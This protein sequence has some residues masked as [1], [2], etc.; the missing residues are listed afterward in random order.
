MNLDNNFSY[1]LTGINRLI[2]RLNEDHTLTE[3]GDQRV[4]YIITRYVPDNSLIVAMSIFDYTKAIPSLT[5]ITRD[6]INNHNGYVIFDC[7]GN[8]TDSVYQYRLILQANL[9]VPFYMLTGEFNYYKNL[10][11]NPYIKFFPFWT[12]WASNPY[13]KYDNFINYNFS[14]TPKKYKLSC[15]NGSR[16]HHR[17]WTYLQLTRKPYFNE[18]VF[19]YGNRQDKNPHDYMN[20][21]QL[22]S[23]ENNQL[24]QLPSEV[25]FIDDDEFIGIDITINHPAYQET[26]INLVTETNINGSMS[27]LSEKTFKPIVAGQLFV[28]I[29][30]PKSIQFLRDIGIDTF[31][32][33]IDHSYDTIVDSRLRLETV[34]TQI[35]YLMTVDLKQLYNQIKP[36]LQRNSE[37]F[38]SKEFRQQFPLTFTE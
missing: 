23:E 3:F 12:V 31:D 13:S 6:I 30:A 20:E 8:I 35:D 1:Q 37:Y 16:W 9:S 19:S 7:S 18:L 17:K 36:R 21:I 28:L 34:I 38:R 24:I 26:Y 10:P 25:K 2:Y 29:A 32:D 5:D 4:E 22:T 11:A 27:M 15:L 14:E 33:I